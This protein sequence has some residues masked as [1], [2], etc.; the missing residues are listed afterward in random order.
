VYCDYHQ[1]DWLQLLPLA[2]FV[3]NNTQSSSTLMSPFYANY[4]YH[5][6]CTVK[7]ATDTVNPAADDLVDRLQAIHAD[8]KLRLR[9]AQDK[10]KENYDAR[11]AS[12]PSFAVGDK[13]WL[14][15]KNIRTT[16]PSQKLDTKRMGPFKVLGVVGDGELAYR[17]EL[18]GSMKQ[19]H[20][21][22]HVSLLEPYHENRWV[23]RVQPPPPPEEIEGELEYEVKE[24]LDSR[25][26]RGKLQY[27]VDWVGYGPEERTWEP[28][29]AVENAPAAVAMFHQAYP[30][31][32]SKG[33]LQRQRRFRS[34]RR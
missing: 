24:I 16:R 31:R 34:S 6:R 27:L 1:D 30:D 20:P 10:Y 12:T 9:C 28:E 2:E 18:P 29:E 17:L 25:V 11:T 26:I 19:I 5:P 32:P 22:F 7:L 23:E 33:T 13:V 3:Y 14:L 4:S 8:L 21:V 15:R